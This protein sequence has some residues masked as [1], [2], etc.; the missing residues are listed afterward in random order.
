MSM[1]PTIHNAIISLCPEARLEIQGKQIIAI[2]N[3]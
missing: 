3:G 1:S 2:L